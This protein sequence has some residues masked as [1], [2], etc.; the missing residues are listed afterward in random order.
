LN[1][2]TKEELEALEIEDRTKTILEVK[3]VLTKKGLMLQLEEKAQT[4]DI[5][6]QRFFSKVDSLH[7]KGLLGLLV[8]NDKLIT[9][10]DYKQNILTVEK[11]GSKFAGIQGSITGKDFLETLQLD[12]SI[13]HE[14]K[15]IFIT[16]PTFSKYTEM[17]ETY[18]RLLKVSIPSQKRW[19]DLCALIE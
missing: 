7:K 10:S 19:E 2:K 5:G 13:Q 15:Y 8:I 11:D 3:K 4:M 9:L 12:L 14:I 16:K 18:R 1:S 17:D 6:V